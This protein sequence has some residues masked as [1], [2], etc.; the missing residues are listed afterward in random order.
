MTLTTPFV[1]V[2]RHTFSASESPDFMALYKL[3]FNFNFTYAELDSNTTDLM[4]TFDIFAHFR[5]FYYRNPSSN[6]N[7]TNPNHNPRF[8]V[9]R[10]RFT[11]H[12][13]VP[14]LCC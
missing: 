2:I 3:V 5:T 11:S 14:V 10:L 12:I 9:G 6:R 8:R 4:W 1:R 7:G 13:D